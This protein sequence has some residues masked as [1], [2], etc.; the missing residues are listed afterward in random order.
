[1]MSDSHS[2]AQIV[3]PLAFLSVASAPIC[4]RW[5]WVAMTCLRSDTFRPIWPIAASTRAPSVSNS[6]S[7]S[8]SDPLSS[9]R[10]AWTRPPILWL[11][12]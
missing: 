1:M 7:I 8:V 11:S 9:I 12:T 2:C 10:K 3:A 4:E 6:V 5:A